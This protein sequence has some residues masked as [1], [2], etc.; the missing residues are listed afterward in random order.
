MPVVYGV[1]CPHLLLFD[2]CNNPQR[3][4]EHNCDPPYIRGDRNH[5]SNSVFFF[6]FGSKTFPPD[7]TMVRGLAVNK[8]EMQDGGVMFA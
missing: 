1:F 3:R 5:D 7:P 8:G 4:V 6:F 2:S